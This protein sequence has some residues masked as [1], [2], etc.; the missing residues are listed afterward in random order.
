MNKV[1]L[2]IIGIGEDGLAGL[3]Q[4]GR[5]AVDAAEIFVG[6]ERHLAMLGDDPR[7]RLTWDSPLGK[8]LAK[9]R[10]LRG[11]QVCVLATG[12]P[13]SYGIGVTLTAE[14]GMAQCVVI[15][16]QSAFSLACARLGWPLAE[17]DCLTLHG[18]PLGLLNG[19]LRPNARLLILSGDGD[20]P[21]LVAQILKAAG[22]GESGI[23]VLEH[24][25]GARENRHDGLAKSWR[26]K[27]KDLNTIALHCIADRDAP[28]LMRPAGLADDLFRHD[29]QLTK[30]EVRAV[31]LAAL[32]PA[33]GEILW[34]VGAGAGSIAI[35]FLRAEPTAQAIAIEQNPKRIA[36]IRANQNNLGVS[37]LQIIKGTAPVALK[38]LAKPDV[39]FIGGGVSDGKLLQ[40]CWRALPSG[41]RFVAN[42]VSAE[43]EAEL[44]RFMG[45]QG[46]EMT[47]IAVSHMDSMGDL[48]AWRAMRPVTQY[49]GI[50]S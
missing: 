3:D 28:R 6:G 25:G 40:A 19:H 35:E 50:K 10:G 27:V 7:P 31:T 41:G 15:P 16:R 33:P 44:F 18:R 26:G 17:V 13:M 24:M 45:R 9:I 1:W 39:I 42:A 47:R 43:G 23:T 11:R 14:F 46:G 30:R 4:A 21:K 49:R 22:Y 20:T 5:A 12:D 48:H 2:S 34:D 36:N 37:N 32:A 29:G 8:T 38:G